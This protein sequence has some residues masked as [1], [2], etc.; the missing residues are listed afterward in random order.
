MITKDLF[1]KYP[2]L[3]SFGTPTFRSLKRWSIPA[4]FSNEG[5]KHKRRGGAVL[6]RF[7]GRVPDTMKSF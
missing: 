4:A 5:K 6:E 2:T 7:G 1:K 3:A